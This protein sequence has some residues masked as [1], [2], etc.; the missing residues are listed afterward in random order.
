[1]SV[2]KVSELE[3][4]IF[5]GDK[6]GKSPWKRTVQRPRSQRLGAAHYWLP[7]QLCFTA[8]THFHM[9]VT[10]GGKGRTAPKE[11]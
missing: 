5:S 2:Q 7:W 1:M 10:C 6:D 4:F 11:T 8:G 3:Y 9:T